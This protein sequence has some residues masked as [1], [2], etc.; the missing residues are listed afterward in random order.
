M[1][2]AVTNSLCPNHAFYR[3]LNLVP[4]VL[5]LTPWRGPWERGC[6]DLGQVDVIAQGLYCDVSFSVGQNGAEIIA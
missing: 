2:R 5:S 3:D 1:A 6:R 4:R